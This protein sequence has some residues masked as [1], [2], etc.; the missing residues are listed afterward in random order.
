MIRA[1]SVS[2]REAVDGSI[3]VFAKTFEGEEPRE[4][5]DAF[6]QKRSPR[7]TSVNRSS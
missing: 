7:W 1:R 3:E 6:L 2:L 5:A 4:G